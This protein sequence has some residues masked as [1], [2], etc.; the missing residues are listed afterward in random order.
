MMAVA[1]QDIEARVRALASESIGASGLRLVDVEYRREAAGWILRLVIDKEGGVTLDDCQEVSHEIAALLEVEDPIPQ[2]FTLEVTS[3]GLNRPLKSDEDYLAAVGR[4]VKITTRE[5][6]A[7]QRRFSG[8]IIEASAEEPPPG[9][10]R[11]S[12]R[13]DGGKEIVLGSVDI[14]KANVVHEWPDTSAKKRGV[15]RDQ[16]APAKRGAAG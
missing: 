3:P 6:V 12:L 9:G 7:G 4:L 13:M 15:R 14:E 16:T 11:I 1:A 10:T 2:H 5:P 8:R